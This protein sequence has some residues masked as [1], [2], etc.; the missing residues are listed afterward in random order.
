RPV[1]RLDDKL[2]ADF[3]EE[4]SATAAGEGDYTGGGATAL[5]RCLAQAPNQS[6]VAT[7]LRA[8]TRRRQRRGY[9][10]SAGT[11]SASGDLSRSP[12]MASAQAW[13]LLFYLSYRPCPPSLRHPS[14]TLCR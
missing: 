12:I 3:S 10:K 11:P 8:V 7:A 9:K 2:F 13:L 6:D 14:R 4:F 1:V 5:I